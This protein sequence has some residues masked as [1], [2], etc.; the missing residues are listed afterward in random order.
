MPTSTIQRYNV[1]KRSRSGTITISPTYNS[2]S[3]WNLV[4]MALNI[5]SYGEYI[6]SSKTQL[7]IFIKM[8]GA[9]GGSTG[10]TQFISGGGGGYSEGI[11]TLIPDVQYR[12]VIGESGQKAISPNGT[13]ITVSGG[14]GGASAIC[15]YDS[16]SPILVAGGGGGS[17][18]YAAYYAG[19]GGGSTGQDAQSGG[20]AGTQTYA[21]VGGIGSRRNGESGNGADGGKG[22]PTSAPSF[23]IGGRGYG[24]GGDG[25]Y[26]YDDG[27][28]GGGGGGYYGGGGGGG[29][30]GGYAGGGGSGYINSTLITNGLLETGNYVIPARSTDSDRGDSGGTVGNHPQDGRIIISLQQ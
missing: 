7:T 3:Q 4:E 5:N 2:T 28:S 29:D 20:K 24:K 13:R 12:V 9:A 16:N 25:V 22:A 19:A 30:M 17:G 26:Y 6:I 21:G 8:W 10:Y 18:T 11:L 15:L 27:P 23:S 14:G 1:N